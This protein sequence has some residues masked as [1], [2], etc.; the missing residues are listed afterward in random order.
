[1]KNKAKYIQIKNQLKKMRFKISPLIRTVQV[2]IISETKI[3]SNS[4]KMRI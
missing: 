2:T 4:T 3:P 1:M